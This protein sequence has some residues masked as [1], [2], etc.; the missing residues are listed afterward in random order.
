NKKF[1]EIDLLYQTADFSK[2]PIKSASILHF[3]SHSV[4]ATAFTDT[5]FVSTSPDISKKGLWLESAQRAA[6]ILNLNLAILNGCNTGAT[7]S[8]NYFKKFLT[9]EKV[10]LSSIFLLNRQCFVA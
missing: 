4:S 6:H 1:A 9:H 3:S 7:M 2:D 8:W 10:G 5:N